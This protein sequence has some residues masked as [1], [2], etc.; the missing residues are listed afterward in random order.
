M[1]GMSHTL[2]SSSERNRD[3]TYTVC[4]MGSEG[5]SGSVVGAMKIGVIDMTSHLSN[6]LLKSH[7]CSKTHL[8]QELKNTLISR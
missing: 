3:D 4:W 1:A 6:E 8:S 5:L 7:H 2:A